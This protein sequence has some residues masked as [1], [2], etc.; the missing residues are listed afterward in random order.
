MIAGLDLEHRNGEEWSSVWCFDHTGELLYR[1]PCGCGGLAVGPLM[2][3]GH[4]YGVGMTNSR[5]GGSHGLAEI[6]CLNLSDGTLAWSHPVDRVYLDAQNPVMADVSC[7]APALW[8]EK[9]GGGQCS[10]VLPGP[11]AAHRHYPDLHHRIYLCLPLRKGRLDLAGDRD[12]RFHQR[13]RAV[14]GLHAIP[15]GPV[16]TRLGTNE[17]RGCNHPNHF[18]EI[19]MHFPVRIKVVILLG[20]VLALAACDA[21]APEPTATP[22]PSETFTPVP[23]ETQPPEPTA[24]PEPTNTPTE[25]PTETPEPT[26]TID[27]ASLP[28]PIPKD[29]PLE[30]WNDIPIMEGAISGQ[31]SIAAYMFIIYADFDEIQEYYE[32]EMGALGWDVS[33]ISS[34]GDQTLVLRFLKDNRIVKL[35]VFPANETLKIIV[36]G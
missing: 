22:V 6:R 13:N 27:A 23:T 12:A 9:G 36:I 17:K 16:L 20:F 35:G 26:P 29:E 8:L 18:K 10:A 32:Q 19:E 34:E 14:R 11:P 3:D 25:V 1:A 5:D 24:T 33:V 28:F 31:D 21:G 15:H 7:P 30:A 2:G 4:L